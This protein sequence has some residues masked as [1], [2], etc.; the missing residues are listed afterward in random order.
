MLVCVFVGVCVVVVPL[1]VVDVVERVC[2]GARVSPV[3]LVL[4]LVV[5]LLDA[6]VNLSV[7][8]HGAEQAEAI[9][10]AIPLATA[11]NSRRMISPGTGLA[12]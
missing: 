9:W 6:D 7:A 3:A 8:S 11:P 4:V 10:M 2:C 1:L 12:R 5:L